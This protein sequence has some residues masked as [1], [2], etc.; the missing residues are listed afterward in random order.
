M[1]LPACVSE[2]WRGATSR[3]MNG[4]RWITAEVVNSTL[5]VRSAGGR[6]DRC[7]LSQMMLRS[8]DCDIRLLSSTTSV[9]VSSTNTY[10]KHTLVFI[11]P[12]IT[13]TLYRLQSE[14][15]FKA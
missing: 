7:Q 8:A 14:A 1:G 12:F 6:V 10:K 13:Y 15:A 11:H 4:W 2:S 9:L 5:P 3:S